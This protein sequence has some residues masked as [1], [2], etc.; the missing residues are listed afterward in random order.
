MNNTGLEFIAYVTLHAL[1]IIM[2]IINLSPVV[3]K[4]DYRLT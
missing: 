3:K 2:V 4:N 1:D